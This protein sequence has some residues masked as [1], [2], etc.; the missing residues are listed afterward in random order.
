M[1][2]TEMKRFDVSNNDVDDKVFK[3]AET[4]L[5]GLK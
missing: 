2:E 4:L 5:D 3:Q 1:E